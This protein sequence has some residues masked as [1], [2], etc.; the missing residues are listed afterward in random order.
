M[1]EQDKDF[2]LI[3]NKYPHISSRLKLL[4]GS[5][6]CYNYFGNLL[7]DTRDGE[8]QGFSNE[9]ASSIYRLSV[10]HDEQFPKFITKSHNWTYAR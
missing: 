10:L 7:L 3:D 4:W 8:R 6:E 1:L 9:V 5:K 2:V